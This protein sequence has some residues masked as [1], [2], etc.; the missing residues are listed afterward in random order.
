MKL[1]YISYSY[2]SSGQA[3]CVHVMK[4]CQAFSKLGHDVTLFVPND[5]VPIDNGDIYNHFG[6]NKCFKIKK[7][8]TYFFIGR[9][10]VFSFMCRFYI[11]NFD[12]I[13]SRSVLACACVV[14]K[15][16]KFVFESHIPVWKISFAEVLAF[17]YIKRSPEFMKLVVISGVLKD[18]YLSNNYIEK[19]KILVAHDGADEA[20]KVKLELPWKGR[21]GALQVGYVGHLFPGR[22]VE[23]VFSI[24]ERFPNAD[25]HIVGG[26]EKDLSFWKSKNKLNNVYLYGYVAPS[27]TDFYRDKCDILLMPYQINLTIANSKINTV[28]WMSPLK[29]FEYM[30]AKKAIISSDL[31]VIRE[32]LND[33]NSMLVP[34]NNVDKWSK[35]ISDLYNKNLRTKISNKAYEDFISNYTWLTRASNVSSI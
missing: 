28:E 10:H 27:H 18:M 17:K 20:R 6:V 32:V 5:N 30:S 7:I 22:G 2:L 29:M 21:G 24:A 33:S 31:P 14:S 3:N 23:I 16:T 1:A 4:M 25:F 12:L 8:P 35:A 15:K 13:Y 9:S 11:K 34:P 19:E 26:T